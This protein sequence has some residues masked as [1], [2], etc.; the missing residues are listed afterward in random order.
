MTHELWIDHAAGAYGH[1]SEGRGGGWA[2]LRQVL[3]VRTTREALKAGLEVIVEDHFYLTSISRHKPRGAPEAMLVLARRHW[4]IENCLHHTKDRSLAEDAD[5]THAGATVMARLR[6]LAVGLLQ[7]IAGKSAPQKQIQV[8]A[9]P[10]IA[11]RL[12]ARKRLPRI[13]N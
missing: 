12:L 3:C 8:A 1:G 2:G 7:H 10:G 5:R 13:K 6:S 9:D 4:E 11:L